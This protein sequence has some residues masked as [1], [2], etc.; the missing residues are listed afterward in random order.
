MEEFSMVQKALNKDEKFIFHG[1]VR[2]KLKNVVQLAPNHLSARILYL[3][4]IKKSPKKLSI[5]GSLNGIDSAT[6]KLSDMLK[7]GTFNSVSGLQ[8]DELSTLLSEMARLRPSLDNRSTKY[9]D[10]I[11]NIS[12]FL[13]RNR[14]RK[15]ISDQLS[16]EF[17]Q[18]VQTLNTERQRLLNDKDIREELME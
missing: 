18:L 9:A 16:R 15:Q 13:K 10:S 14:D 5:I 4:S 2:Q 3:H 11:T 8:E 1:Q 12:Q 7:N 6:E 17:R